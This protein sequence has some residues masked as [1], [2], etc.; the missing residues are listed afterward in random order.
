MSTILLLLCTT[1]C[2]EADLGDAPFYCNHGMPACPE[3]YSC[4]EFKKVKVCVR[5]GHTYLPE[6]PDAGKD[7]SK[8]VGQITFDGVKKDQPRPDAPADVAQQL[9]KPQQKPDLLQPDKPQLPKDKGPAPDVPHLG[10]QT[11]SECKKK[12]SQYP[13]CCPTPLVPFI[14]SCLPLCLNPLCLP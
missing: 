6:K 12:D 13:C 4:Q 7:A 2:V 14:W 8:D 9:D 3:G 10:C 5:E 1:A 11:N